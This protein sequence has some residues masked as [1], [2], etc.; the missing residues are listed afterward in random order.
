MN[1]VSN[2]SPLINLAWIGKLNLIRQLYGQITIPQAVWDEIVVKGEG[3]PG[4]EEIRFSDWIQVQPAKNRALIRSFQQ[5]LDSGEA[6]AIVLAL[7]IEANL[8]LMDERIGRE[9]A[10]YFGLQVIGLIGV[11]IESKNH[12]YIDAVK[13]V[14]IHLRTRAGFYIKPALYQRILREQ[15]ESE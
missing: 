11:L 14:L 10:T 7:E 3:Q 6:E 1:V 2:A 12:G 4:A 5:D 8:L 13:P 15:N 9:T